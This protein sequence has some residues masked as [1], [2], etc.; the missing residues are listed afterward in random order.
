MNR[1]Q[2]AGQ[3]T[4]VQD[5]FKAAKM[6]IVT[7]FRG[8][9]VSQMVQLRR[10]VYEASG[11]YKVIK[12]TMARLALKDGVFSSLENLLKGPN[13]WVFSYEDPVKLSKALVK[14]SEQ[15]EMLKIKGGVLEGEFLEAAT[16]KELAKMPSRPELQAKLLAV[17][18]APGTQ[19][20]RLIQEPAARVA[21]LVENLRKTKSEPES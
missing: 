17:M 21:R 20:V 9:T 12:N 2:K 6:A 1:E 3:V 15:H 11:E 7:E 5:K 8:L 16:V 18:L 19:L 13:G 14:F 4:E 10:E